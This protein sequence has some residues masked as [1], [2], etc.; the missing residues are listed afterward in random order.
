MSRKIAVLVPIDIL[1]L[2]AIACST[3]SGA[4]R[5]AYNTIVFLDAGPAT[6][7]SP[8]GG[9]SCPP[10]CNY[11]TQ[12]GCA[13]SQMCQP[14][15]SSENTVSP[16]CLTAGTKAAGESCKQPDD[17]QAGLI[18]TADGNC[19]HMCCGGDWSVCA[20]NES[21]AG[22]ILLASDAGSPVSA[23]VNVCQPVDACDVLNP[24]SCPA[25]ESCYIVDSRAG[26]RCLTTGTVPLNES[27]TSAELCV[28]G[29][30]CV[31]DPNPPY[32]TNCRRLCRAVV[33]GGAPACPASE[34][35]CS[36]FVRD[37]PDVG[38]CTPTI[39]NGP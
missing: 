36:H 24:N 4:D 21:C 12:Q 22:T 20:S 11:Q 3:S 27:C 18:C 26:V 34:G 30:T 31:Q 1:M 25:G 39:L 9:S 23:H 19:H 29:F 15:L 5:S 38:E 7:V 16:E 28:A 8:D 2:L 6:P 14:Y 10:G 37:P 33:G 17:C 13:A 35:D 32:S